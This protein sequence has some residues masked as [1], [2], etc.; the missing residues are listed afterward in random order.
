M[1]VILWAEWAG[2]YPGTERL[3]ASAGIASRGV[4]GVPTR[5]MAPFRVHYVDHGDIP[6]DFGPHVFPVEKYGILSGWLR[7]ELGV[8]EERIHPPEEIGDDD[9][10]RVHV[11]AYV[12]D[13][14]HARHSWAT[15]ISELPV[16]AEVI[17]G[18]L[19][20]A[21]GSL[22]AV[23]LALEHGI[24]FHIGG[25]F[26]HAYPDHAEGFCYVH[27]VA[28]AIERLRAEAKLDKVLVVDVDVHQGNG[29]AVIYR[30]DDQTFTYSI[31]QENNYPVKEE[32]DW[33]RGLEDGVGDAEYVQRL[34]SDLDAIAERFTPEFVCYL[35]GVDPYRGDQLGGLGLSSD[36]LAARDRLVF[37]R[38]V[39]Q[40]IPLAVFLAGGYAQSPEETAELHLG[41]A[42][43]AEEV[44]RA[45]GAHPRR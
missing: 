36:G 5:F 3:D 22:T 42:R 18:F 15:A 19:A 38:F 28:I 40:G 8:A 1:R 4:G 44:C 2:A 26:H 6:M 24:G 14:K 39:G 31:H 35:A 27:D 7:S 9:L 17:Q 25:G 33:D 43:A 41:T 45:R 21:G 11:P 34:T 29:T 12:S 32:S 30:G 37:E 20:M 13:L 23:R 10:A 16:D